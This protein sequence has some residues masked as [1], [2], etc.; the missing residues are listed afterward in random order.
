MELHLLSSISKIDNI[1]FV[2]FCFE[3]LNEVSKIIYICT[4]PLFM[5]SICL[6]S[7]KILYENFD[8]VVSVP[9]LERAAKKKKKRK[10]SYS[11]FVWNFTN[12]L[13][14]DLVSM[15][16]LL[17]FAHFILCVSNNL[18]PLSGPCCCC[19]WKHSENSKFIV[20]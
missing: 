11:L 18:Y 4:I 19:F 13:A 5:Y 9:K 7:L 14:S 20:N 15:I 16:S 8:I 17:H 2:L 10:V 6:E 3:L 1:E 12:S